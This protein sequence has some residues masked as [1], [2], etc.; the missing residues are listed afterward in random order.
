MVC[1]GIGTGLL[2]GVAALAIKGPSGH[3]VHTHGAASIVTGVVSSPYLYV[4]AGSWVTFMLLYQVGVAALPGLHPLSRC[5]LSRA[6]C[7]S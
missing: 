2:Y 3:L 6:V 1:F 4:F 5:P 7:T